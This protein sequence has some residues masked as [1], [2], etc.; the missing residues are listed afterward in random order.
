MAASQ[1]LLP[2][3]ERARGP[4]VKDVVAP[5]KLCSVDNNILLSISCAHKQYDPS[6]SRDLGDDLGRSAEVGE[7]GVEGDDVYSI[8]DTKDV[9]AVARVPEGGGM[10]KVCLGCQEHWKGE[11]AG[12]RGGDKVEVGSVCWHGCGPKSS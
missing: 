9:G 5:R 2:V 11:F 6:T 1:N 8:A 12:G 4:A 3:G 7:C 10:A